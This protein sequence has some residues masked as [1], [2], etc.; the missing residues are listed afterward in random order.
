MAGVVAS[1]RLIPLHGTRLCAKAVAAK[2]GCEAQEARK[3]AS[4]LQR[5]M[6]GTV[7]KM[8]PQVDI[9]STLQL[10]NVQQRRSETNWIGR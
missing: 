4:E 7:E 2:A 8:R 5:K 10:Y 1:A 6:G 9:D 3:G